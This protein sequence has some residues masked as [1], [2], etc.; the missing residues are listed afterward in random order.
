MFR[1]VGTTKRFVSD[2][3]DIQRSLVSGHSEETGPNR[4]IIIGGHQ[5]TQ[6]DFDN[7]LHN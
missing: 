5:R 4:R 7:N 3:R 1:I 2:R 6:I